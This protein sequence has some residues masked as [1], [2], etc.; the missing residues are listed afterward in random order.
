MSDIVE[1]LRGYA[2][3]DHERGCAG[4]CYDCSCGYDAKRDPL[5]DE[6]ADEI[7]RLRAALD[8]IREA[9]DMGLATSMQGAPYLITNVHTLARAA[10][11]EKA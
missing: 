3:D 7:T 2:A 9:T 1:R 11:G 4:R 10:L 5:M 6:A 8:A